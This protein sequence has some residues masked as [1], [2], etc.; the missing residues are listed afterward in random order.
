MIKDKVSKL[1]AYINNA[2]GISVILEHLKATNCNTMAS[3]LQTFYIDI[4][5]K[6]EDLKNEVGKE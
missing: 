2:T 5:N 1:E 4:K 6:T 3:L